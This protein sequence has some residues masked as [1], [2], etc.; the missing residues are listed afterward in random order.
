MATQSAPPRPPKVKST[1]LLILDK[2]FYFGMSLLVPLIVFYGFS[3]TVDQNLIHATP[4]RPWILW[5]HGI[6]MT[7]WLVFFIFQSALVR[8]HNVKIHRLTG[9]FG[10][11]LAA[12][13]TVIGVSTA[14]VMDRFLVFQL[15]VPNEQW[16]FSIQIWDMIAFTTCFWLAVYWR[17]KPEFHR[18]L[19]L[20]ATCALTAAAWGRMPWLSHQWFYAGVDALILLGIV[21][22][23]I[24]TRRIHVVYRYALPAF[25]VAQTCAVNLWVFHPGWWERL[26]SIIVR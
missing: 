11:A 6:V 19:V 17:K 22:D 8:T 13:I 18:R 1:Y 15:H 2:Y 3:Y 7:A 20:V 23:L 5:T 21:R 24:V 10:A 16:F 26:T 14:V 12:L 9:W 25:V 4:P